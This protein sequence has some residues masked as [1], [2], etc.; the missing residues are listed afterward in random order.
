VPVYGSNGQIGWHDER[1]VK[2]PGI[3]VG[4]KGN[5]GTVVWSQT[6][7]FPIDTT[8]Y[9]IPR[10]TASL[11]Y[12]LYVLKSQDLPSLSADSAVPGLNRNI[13]YMNNILVPSAQV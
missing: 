6:D 5:P 4:R 2:G 8:F 11:H 12:L 9:V 7:F 10:G 3:I 13:A 1:L